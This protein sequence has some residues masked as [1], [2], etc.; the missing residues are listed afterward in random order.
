MYQMINWFVIQV[1]ID[2]VLIQIVFHL[3]LIINT[4]P[5]TAETQKYIEV[6][7]NYE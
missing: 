2:C 4:K 6:C 3:F 1:S 5:K 7:K